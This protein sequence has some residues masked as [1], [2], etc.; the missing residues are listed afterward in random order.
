LLLADLV[1][2]SDLSTPFDK[3]RVRKSYII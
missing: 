2:A 3:L 1:E